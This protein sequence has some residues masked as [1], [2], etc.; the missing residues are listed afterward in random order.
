MIG[1]YL[2]ILYETKPMKQKQTKIKMISNNKFFFHKK[3]N[4]HQNNIII[5]RI[6]SLMISFHKS[7]TKIYLVAIR[8]YII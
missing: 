6:F 8:H 3:Q 7:L 4:K 5:V 1:I 2:I